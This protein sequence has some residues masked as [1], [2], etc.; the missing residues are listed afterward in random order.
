M[1]FCLILTCQEKTFYKLETTDVTDVDNKEISGVRTC[2]KLYHKFSLC[3]CFMVISIFVFIGTFYAD[4][5]KNFIFP[6][7][8]DKRCQL[9]T[10]F[11][12]WLLVGAVNPPAGNTEHTVI[13]NHLLF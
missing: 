11:V 7:M 5:Q 1:I 6:W 10:M 12:M 4:F 13:S 9:V 2:Q 3:P 8:L